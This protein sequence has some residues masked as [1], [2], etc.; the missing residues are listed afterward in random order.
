[1][2]SKLARVRELERVSLIFPSGFKYRIFLGHLA[3]E[4]T[5]SE[6]K[7]EPLDRE[8]SPGLKR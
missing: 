4:I 6:G 2:Q 7:P 3:M 5:N 8:H 1:M